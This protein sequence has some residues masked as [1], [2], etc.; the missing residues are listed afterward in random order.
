[1]KKTLTTSE[2]TDDLLQPWLSLKWSLTIFHNTENASNDRFDIKTHK[3]VTL[4]H[5]FATLEAP[6]AVERSSTYLYKVWLFQK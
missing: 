3:P 2:A 6:L 5:V 1:M 4:F